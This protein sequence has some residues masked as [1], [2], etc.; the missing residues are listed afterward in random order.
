M[1]LSLAPFHRPL[2]NSECP[3]RSS[4]THAVLVRGCWAELFALGLAQCSEILS[5]PTILSSIINHLQASVAQEKISALHIKQVT[6]PE[7]FGDN[8]TLFEAIYLNFIHHLSFCKLKSPIKSSKMKEDDVEWKPSFKVFWER[9]DLST[10]V[11][12]TLTDVI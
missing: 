1:P 11:K 2:C 3:F 4:D 5:L 7:L 6:W 8:V 12:K 9:A 10:K